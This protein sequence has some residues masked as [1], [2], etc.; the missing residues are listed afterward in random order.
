MI[1]FAAAS[2]LRAG[3]AQ[4]AGLDAE[5]LTPAAR[6]SLLAQAHGSAERLRILLATAMF[7]AET[8]HAPCIDLELAQ[9]A[10][11]LQPAEAVEAPAPLPVRMSQRQLGLILAAWTILSV[12]SGVL[13]DE[14]IRAPQPA[15]PD[16]NAP[17]A[18]APPPGPPAP[19]ATAPVSQPEAAQSAPGPAALPATTAP[20]AQPQNQAPPAVTAVQIPA[21]APAAAPAPTP[22][23]APPAVPPPS[24]VRV[25]LVRFFLA[26]PGAAPRA[27]FVE[28][29]LSA[30][31]FIVHM[32][33]DTRLPPPRAAAVV[34]FHAEDAA[35]AQ[36]AE[37]AA[38]LLETRPVLVRTVSPRRPVRGTIEFLLP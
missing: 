34:Y 36:R 37:A 15:R 1:R 29:R 14:A 22:A 25:V 21:P 35:I 2:A 3:D 10:G 16:V 27:R 30:A 4:F 9:R 6:Q 31:G 18:S 7:L 38:V 13:L 17:A 28:Q 32:I 5:Q 20:A 11:A 23:I 12:G 19:H 26:S 33:P 24:P 8:E